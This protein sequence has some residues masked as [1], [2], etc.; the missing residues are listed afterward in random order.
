MGNIDENRSKCLC[1]A[2]RK[3]DKF[4]RWRFLSAALSLFAVDNRIVVHL[5]VTLAFCVMTWYFNNRIIFDFSMLNH[6]RLRSESIEARS[7]ILYNLPP[8]RCGTRVALTEENNWR[9]ISFHFF[10]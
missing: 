1:K 7:V 4:F 8:G 2:I 3:E 5:L 9:S 10:L 6:S